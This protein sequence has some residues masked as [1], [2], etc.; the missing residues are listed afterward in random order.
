MKAEGKTAAKLGGSSIVRLIDQGFAHGV[1][2]LL[3]RRE[4]D[5]PLLRDDFIAN[6]DGELA[7]VAL[8]QFGLHAEFAFKHGRH[9]DGSGF[10][11]PSGLA[12]ADD[13]A[14]HGVNTSGHWGRFRPP[15]R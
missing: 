10:V 1:Q 11:R 9:P 15:R 4:K 14:D 6:A 8:G 5:E 13:E 2:N 3:L 12:V 7:E